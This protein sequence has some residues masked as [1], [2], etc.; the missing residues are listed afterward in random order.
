MASDYQ[1]CLM[2]AEKIL[3][4]ENWAFIHEFWN[5]FGTLDDGDNE[6]FE[7]I[8]KAIRQLL[9]EKQDLRLQVSKALAMFNDGCRRR[10]IDLETEHAVEKALKQILKD[11]S[12]PSTLNAT[13]GTK[14]EKIPDSKR[15]DTLASQF[16]SDSN[17]P[18]K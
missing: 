10:F 1:H 6:P 7:L 9:Y 16:P 4:D 17:P 12:C 5:D 13:Y 3:P 11:T 14:Q 8:R 15:G 2:L 18:T